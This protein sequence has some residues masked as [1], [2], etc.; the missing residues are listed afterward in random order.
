M[1]QKHRNEAN[2]QT[3]AGV[4]MARTLMQDFVAQTGLGDS[5]RQPVRY[6][7][8]DAFGVC[9][10]LALYQHTGD[11]IYRR[12][13]LLLIQQVHEVLGQYA[14]EDPRSGCIS[15]LQGAMAKQHPTVGG[16]RIGK[17]ELERAPG[18]ALDRHREWDRDGQY[19]HYLTKWMHALSRAAQITQDPQ[20]LRFALEL[21]QVAHRRFRHD[22]AGLPAG[23]SEK[24]RAHGASTALYRKMSVDLSRPQVAATG[25]HDPL[26]ALLTYRELAM[27]VHQF[28][29]STDLPTL[30]REIEA[31]QIMCAGVDWT[32]DDPL[33]IGGLLF[34]ACRLAQI[35]TA[36]GTAEISLLETILS[37]CLVGLQ[38]YLQSN[39][40]RRPAAS[41]L[42]FRE[43]GLSIGLRAL[44]KIQRLLP[45]LLGQC[46]ALTRRDSALSRLME[47]L[48]Q[49]SYL[50]AAIE[51][52]W[53]KPASQ[54]T[55]NWVQHLNINTVMLATSLVPEAFLDLGAQSQVTPNRR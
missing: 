25:L 23:G 18:E 2:S 17:P 34:D 21:A 11:E 40:L 32:T 19:F 22:N 1:N 29:T 12:Q 48:A 38:D 3:R 16:L 50:S 15:G 9:N 45:Q 28:G 14:S 43:L 36:A 13:A 46:T 24:S 4:V 55:A 54:Q 51:A 37:C 52:F 44:P 10:F 42:A 5:H 26:D 8:T 20:L 49:F 27:L 31:A 33:G 41:R 53:L 30:T 7:W 47:D 39:P 6:L 35:E